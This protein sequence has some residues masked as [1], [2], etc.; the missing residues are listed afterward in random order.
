VAEGPANWT[1]AALIA[2]IVALAPQRTGGVHLHGPSG[3]ARDQWLALLAEIMPNEMPLR[4]C[5]ARIDEERLLGGLDLAASLATSTS[6][7]QR[8]LLSETDGGIVVFAMAECLPTGLGAQIA[9]V[10]DQGLVT[11]ARDGINTTL[12]ARL[13]IVLLDEG[14]TSEER[15]P[16]ALRERCAFAIPTPSLSPKNW[17]AGSTMKAIVGQAT[18]LLNTREP[19]PDD[20]LMTL[21]QT[22]FACGIDSFRPVLF[23]IE[24][25]Q[26]LAALDGRTLINFDDANIAARLAFAHKATKIPE[27]QAQDNEDQPAEKA[28]EPEQND[29]QQEDQAPAPPDNAGQSENQNTVNNNQPPPA[30]MMIETVKAA[31]PAQLIAA[32]MSGD[33]PTQRG[34][35]RDGRGSGEAVASAKRGCPVGSRRGAI[36]SGQRIHLIDT[37]RAAAPWQKFRAQGVASS[38]ARV[39]VRSEDIR[40][41]RFI[42]KRETTIVFAVDA[43]GSSA[44]QRLSEAK[45]AVQLML[46]R[47][48]QSR[49]RVALVSFRNDGAEL[50]LPPTRSLTRARRLLGDMVGGGGTPLAMGLEVALKVA[51]S[52][53]SKGRTARLLVLTDG[54]G[55]VARDGTPGR[56]GANSD[57]LAIA[58]HI[59]ASGINTVHIDTA[60]RPRPESR[61]LADKMGAIYAPLPSAQSGELARTIGLTMP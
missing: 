5:P 16:D 52:E 33:G 56:A 13:G 48:Y 28:C 51:L 49:A 23:A 9:H 61:M 43:S 19:L 20:V 46:A 38:T 36:R 12:P 4:R 53:K 41:R 27:T 29:Q 2:A 30:D 50:I 26:I 54:Q 10:L 21:T 58:S 45:G 40:I 22:A 55:N 3:P 8:G 47:A 44:W 1:D 18:Q 7:L 31:L 37:L 15:A 11:V 6:V 57:A 35:D 32:L 39:L 25:C 34:R 42:E 60:L 17:P 14:S 24:I 59:K